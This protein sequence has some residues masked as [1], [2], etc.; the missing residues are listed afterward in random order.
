MGNS[1]TRV[2][3]FAAAISFAAS[4]AFAAKC[5]NTG[6]G[7]NKWVAQFSKEMIAK[8][9]SKSNVKSSLAGLKYNSKVI[10]LDRSQKSFKQDFGKFY[11]RRTQ[12]MVSKGRKMMKKHRKTFARVEKKYGVPAS[13]LTTI[14]GLETAFGHF[15]GKKPIFQSLATLAYDCR[16]TEFFTNEIVSALTIVERGDLKKSQMLGAWAGEIGQT[17]FLPSRFVK[18]ATSFDGNRKIDLY[19]SVP[20]VLASTAAWF[21]GEGWRRGQGWEEG[22]HNYEVLKGWNRATVYQKTIAKLARELHR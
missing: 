10:R 2:V 1:L 16:R 12:G 8:G 21:K 5:G 20:D 11:K 3:L 13:L 9:Y 4:P 6:A 19:H 18:Y 14:W 22:S 17:Q 7:F 15:S